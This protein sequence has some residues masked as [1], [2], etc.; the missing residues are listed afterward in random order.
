MRE[1]LLTLMIDLVCTL[2]EQDKQ[3]IRRAG[4]HLQMAKET[5]NDIMAIYK[6]EVF[7][8][9][10]IVGIVGSVRRAHTSYDKHP[11]VALYNI[12]RAI[13]LLREE[14]VHGS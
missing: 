4:L 9:P 5:V 8:S 3:N 10:R 2:K 14:V 6:D 7:K 1:Q 13:T 11:E 12:N